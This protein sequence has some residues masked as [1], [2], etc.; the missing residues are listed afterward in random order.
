MIIPIIQSIFPKQPSGS[1]LDNEVRKKKIEQKEEKSPEDLSSKKMKKL[2]DSFRV[3]FIDIGM[4]LPTKEGTLNG[5][6]MT[7]LRVPMNMLTNIDYMSTVFR[8]AWVKLIKEDKQLSKTF[9]SYF[10]NLA[11]EQ[12]RLEKMMQKAAIKVDKAQ[13][14]KIEK[15]LQEKFKEKKKLIE[16]K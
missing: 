1:I 7:M 15:K 14:K 16:P 8:E 2:K 10:K 13:M 9:D 11:L 6:G 5:G 3:D 4:V 12:K